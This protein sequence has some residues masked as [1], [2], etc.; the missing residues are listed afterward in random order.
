MQLQFVL[1]WH[2]VNRK[3]FKMLEWKN[4]KR[5]YPKYY[6]IMLIILDFA[7][8]IIAPPPPPQ[9]FCRQ[10]SV[11]NAHTDYGLNI[12]WSA[13]LEKTEF[14]IGPWA[15]NEVRPRRLQHVHQYV[16]NTQSFTTLNPP[17]C[18]HTIRFLTSVTRN[19]VPSTDGHVFGYEKGLL[20]RFGKNG[21]LPRDKVFY[22]NKTCGDGLYHATVIIIIVT[23]RCLVRT[24]NAMRT[25]IYN[26]TRLN[27]RN[28]ILL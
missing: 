17:P 28:I 27:N 23:E 12:F 3:S 11:D 10:L 6:N 8:V 5:A 25:I 21:V 2:I 26:K 20:S 22:S 15:E 9:T 1:C 24:A 14:P 4:Y 13:T 18:P 7:E 16:Y 19:T